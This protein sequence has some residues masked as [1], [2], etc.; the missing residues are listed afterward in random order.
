MCERWRNSPEGWA[1]LFAPV[2]A[3]LPLWPGLASHIEVHPDRTAALLQPLSPLSLGLG[4]PALSSSTSLDL[5][6]PL[7]TAFQ[8][9]SLIPLVLS[10]MKHSLRSVLPFALSVCLVWTVPP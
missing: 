3:F 5:Q 1:S 7:H 6:A 9:A 4:H 8:E 10:N 2:H